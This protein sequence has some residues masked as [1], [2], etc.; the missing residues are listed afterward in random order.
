MSLR[1]SV[2]SSVVRARGRLSPR[3]PVEQLHGRPYPEPAAVPADLRRSHRVDR[4]EVSGR[5]VL[6]L[7]PRAGADGTHLIYL[8]GGAFV[9]PLLSAHW[10]IVRELVKGTGTTVTVP[11]YRLAPEGDANEGYDF[12]RAAWASVVSRPSVERIVVAGDSA[13]GCLAIGLAMILRDAGER[14]PDHVVGFSPAVDVSATHPAVRELD[15]HDPM[16]STDVVMPMAAA[17]ARDRSLQDP[18]VSPLYGYPAGL[19]PVHVVQ[20]GRDILAPDALTFAGNLRRAGNEGRL[21][22]EPGAFHVY[23]GAWWT[24]EAR[25]AFRHVRTLFRGPERADPGSVPSGSVSPA[26]AESGRAGSAGADDDGA[27]RRRGC[28]RRT[29]GPPTGAGRRPEEERMSV[30]I[31]EQGIVTADGRAVDYA[32]AYRWCV[33]SP[34][35]ITELVQDTKAFAVVIAA[36]EHSGPEEQAAAVR[37][38]FVA[39]VPR[40]P[41]ATWAGAAPQGPGPNTPGEPSEGGVDLPAG[42]PAQVSRAET[43]TP[44][45]AP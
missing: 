22:Y 9:M 21:I 15:P 26:S 27:R 2:T 33:D 25:R 11:L 18:L 19:P 32:T 42:A 45:E 20:G 30:E 13:G 36:A 40:R 37:Q 10:W 3:T 23:V 38:A 28:S 39:G 12:L 44:G 16:L 6:R 31:D 5:P 41:G 1:M 7:T 24:P 4:T 34:E 8:H 17:W 35:T 29:S 14:M 43:R